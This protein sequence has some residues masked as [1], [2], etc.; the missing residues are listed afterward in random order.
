ME[1]LASKE[2]EE[3]IAL[4]MQ[5][6][7]EKQNRK[8]EKKNKDTNNTLYARDSNFGQIREQPLVGLEIELGPGIEAQVDFDEAAVRQAAR[9][10]LLHEIRDDFALGGVGADARVHRFQMCIRDRW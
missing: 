3:K 9:P 6:L 2:Q 7:Q 5:K 4:K 1:A 10:A 8:K